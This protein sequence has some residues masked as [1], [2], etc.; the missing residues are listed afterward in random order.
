MEALVQAINLL[1]ADIRRQLAAREGVPPSSSSSSVATFRYDDTRLDDFYEQCIAPYIPE[2]LQADIEAVEWSEI[3]Q[4]LTRACHSVE[5]RKPGEDGAIKDM[6][7]DMWYEQRLD[8]RSKPQ[9][10]H[11]LDLLKKKPAETAVDKAL[12]ELQDGPVRDLLRLAFHHG[13][14]GSKPDIPARPDAPD[15][16]LDELRT[17]LLKLKTEA[18]SLSSLS[19][20]LLSEIHSSRRKLMW[21]VTGAKA[22]E[23]RDNSLWNPEDAE[24]LH[25]IVDHRDWQA[26]MLP[27]IAKPQNPRARGRGRG[28]AGRGRGGRD[29]GDRSYRS[30]QTEGRK[31]SESGT[32]AADAAPAERS[33]TP[34]AKKSTPRKT[35][36]NTGKGKG[37]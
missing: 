21:E 36:K 9:P 24:T 2:Q 11:V 14:R 10:A 5:L 17:E 25:R 13:V 27:K 19:F 22:H 4:L 29:G 34:S 30:R 1:P 20:S 15:T 16:E 23:L 37:K 35:G 7:H 33:A 31:D 28:K 18:R 8:T 3:D 26:R 12:R 32:D 6:L